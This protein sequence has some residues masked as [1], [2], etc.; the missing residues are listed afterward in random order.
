MTF[1]ITLLTLKA[2]SKL[3][4]LPLWAL[5]HEKP[6]LQEL[7]GSTNQNVVRNIVTHIRLD[8]V[9]QLSSNGYQL[10]RWESFLISLPYTIYWKQADAVFISILTVSGMFRRTQIGFVS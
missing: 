7:E 3:L 4:S 6:V 8:D 9:P 10:R 2:G 1:Y 5:Q